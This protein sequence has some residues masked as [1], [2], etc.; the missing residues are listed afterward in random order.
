MDIETII[1]GAGV[2]GLAVAREL[3]LRGQEV[4]VLEA[5]NAIG[6]H[7]SS[8]NSEVVHAGI[9]YP[10]GSLKARLCVAG[11]SMLYDYCERRGVP[12]S[13]LGK[14]IVATTPAQ[15]KT[16]EG[17]VRRGSQN[18]VHDLVTLDG[19]EARR[20]E[21]ELECLAALH[22]PSTGIVDSHAF[23]LA[24]QGDAEA[25]G[26][27]CVLRT[28]VNVVTRRTGGF[29]VHASGENDAD[30]IS[31]SC[32]NLINCAGLGAQQVA[33][34]IEDFPPERIP[35]RF[36]ARGNY[37]SV[38][39]ATPFSR[40]IYPVP[41]EGG[42]GIHLT[43]DLSGRMR[44]G[45]DLHWTNEIDYT[46]DAQITEEF[47]TLVRAYWPEV[48]NRELSSTHCGLRPKISGPGAASA[49]FL[50]E[51]PVDH[52]VPGLV[53]FFGIESPGLTSSLALAEYA[54][55]KLLERS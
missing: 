7:T 37:V 32:S 10:P 26:T 34:S 18:G 22:S 40:L 17:L 36:P 38:S 46:P 2:I 51:G 30:A 14:L 52:G 12:V 1:V 11:R 55:G 45:P 49:D 35:R 42:L 4:L 15:I 25:H 28:R 21:P 5:E 3:A 13:R 50:V 9:Y 16:I 24:L 53:N 44:L 39:G 43:L 41:V 47:Y 29:D 48:M 20:L 8:R 31:I 54:V 19:A 23:M 27:Q 33:G 6:T